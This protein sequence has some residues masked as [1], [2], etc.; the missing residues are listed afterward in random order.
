MKARIAE[1]SWL[2]RK[3]SNSWM[4]RGTIS[5]A[6][7]SNTIPSC[8]GWEGPQSLSCSILCHGK[9]NFPWTRRLQYTRHGN[10]Q[11]I[12]GKMKFSFILSL[13][14]CP[15]GVMSLR[16]VG[17]DPVLPEGERFH[18][19]LRNVRK[20]NRTKSNSSKTSNSYHIEI[21]YFSH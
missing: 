3:R 5:T 19:R 4:E 17:G 11:E 20:T 16:G 18:C 2:L 9:G 8:S 21:F 7:C 1:N 15:W 12:Q 13:T 10:E 6:G 14:L